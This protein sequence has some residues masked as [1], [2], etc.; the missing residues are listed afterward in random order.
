[1]RTL[2]GAP[3][4]RIARL[5]HSRV[6]SLITV[7]VNRIGAAA[8]FMVQGSVAMMMLV[9]QGGLAIALSPGLALTIV[10]ILI[11]GGGAIMLAQGKIRDIGTGM[12]EANHKMMGSATGFLDGLKAACGSRDRG[13]LNSVVKKFRPDFWQFDE[14]GEDLNDW[15]EDDDPPAGNTITMKEALSHLVMGQEY[16]PKAG[17]MYGFELRF[18]CQHIGTRLPNDCWCSLRGWSWFPNVDRALGELG[19]PEGTVQ[20]RVYYGLKAMRVALEE[21]GYE[22]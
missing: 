11:V 9:V 12:V 5:S 4:V 17:F 10:A 1:M 7:E 19:V 3:W 13:L 15:G 8:Q 2:A 22:D 20:S 18:L 14:M 16:N 6:S 21:M